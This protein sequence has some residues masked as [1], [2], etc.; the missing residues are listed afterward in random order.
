[1]Q[2]AHAKKPGDSAL[3]EVFGEGLDL[4]DLAGGLLALL[5]F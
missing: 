1:V 3:G 5:D 2:A 4:V